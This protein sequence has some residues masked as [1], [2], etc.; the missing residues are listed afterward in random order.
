MDQIPINPQDTAAHEQLFPALEAFKGYFSEKQKLLADL[1]DKL[2]YKFVN[3]SLLIEA[4]SHRSAV[5]EFEAHSKKA[6]MKV[7]IGLLRWNERLEFL[8][9]SVLGLT[10]TTMLWRLSNQIDEGQMS[11]MKAASVSEAALA[12]VAKTLNLGSHIFLGRGERQAQGAN[13]DS[14]LADCLEAVF[15]AIYLDG[16]IET[17]IKVVSL[18]LQDIVTL[19]DRSHTDY[20]TAYQEL[21]QQR[22]QITPTYI[23]L[24][25]VGPDHRK[26]FEVGVYLNDKLV[27][28]GLG[29]SKKLASMDAARQALLLEQN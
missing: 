5:S 29:L 21:V 10:V 2:N 13:R 18:H 16:G 23:I 28:K 15:G 6:N 12:K 24:S 27:A 1:E 22:L 3:R 25:E 17:A 9:D 8:G 26:S 7:S 20:K 14:L 11:R 4:L 19:R